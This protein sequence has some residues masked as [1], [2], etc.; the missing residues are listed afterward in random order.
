MTSS[1][2]EYVIRKFVFFGCGCPLSRSLCS[3]AALAHFVFVSHFTWLLSF[4]L[5]RWPDLKYKLRHTQTRSDPLYIAYTNIRFSHRDK[6]FHL[7]NLIRK[8]FIFFLSV[9][10]LFGAGRTFTE[11]NL[12]S[13]SRAATLRRTNAHHKSYSIYEYLSRLIAQSFCVCMRL[14]LLLLQLWVGVRIDRHIHTIWLLSAGGLFCCHTICVRPKHK[15]TRDTHKL[16]SRFE[17]NGLIGQS[18]GFFNSTTRI[19]VALVRAPKN[20]T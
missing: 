1:D 2:S 20:Q 11:S 14:L 10:V 16:A 4:R 3:C 7:T 17:V 6:S 9:F 8:C 19:C 15:L 5:H 12:F 18:C 13:S